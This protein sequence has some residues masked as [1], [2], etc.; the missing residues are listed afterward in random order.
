MAESYR[1]SEKTGMP[2]TDIKHFVEM[3]MQG[4]E[5]I[6][7]RLD[8]I[9]KQKESVI[10]QINELTKTLKTLE[11]KQWYYETAKEAG[12]TEILR[13]MPTEELP[14]QFRQVRQAL[15]GE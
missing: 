10:H 6:N 15:R 12:T 3:A 7:E 13:D 5:T 1:L 2:L 8:L 11:F 9:I 14:E 4:D